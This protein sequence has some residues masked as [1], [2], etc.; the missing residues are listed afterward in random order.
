MVL[1]WGPTGWR[2]LMSAHGYPCSPPS[3]T[4]IVSFYRTYSWLRKT[5]LRRFAWELVTFL[6][7]TERTQSEDQHLRKGFE[8][9]G[10]SVSSHFALWLFEFVFD[11]LST[12]V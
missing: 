4:E 12:R 5:S 9:A 1:L 8:G 3:G 2:F 11:H 7:R 10:G 6:Y